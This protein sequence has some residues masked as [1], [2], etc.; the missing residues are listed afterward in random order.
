MLAHK[1]P[2]GFAALGKDENDWTVIKCDVGATIWRVWPEVCLIGLVERGDGSV[3]A[4]RG[5]V[6]LVIEQS[7]LKMLFAR[8]LLHDLE[9]LVGVSMRGAV[10]IHGEACD[11]HADGFVDLAA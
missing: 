6:T 9:I 7:D 2:V 8:D 1:I 4:L 3:R 5:I 11:A 10:P